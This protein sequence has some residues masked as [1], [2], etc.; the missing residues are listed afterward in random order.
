[1]F[2]ENVNQRRR[3]RPPGPSAQG[4]AARDR[5]YETAIRMISARGYEATTLREI[6]KEAGV[7]VGLV[8]KYFAKKEDILLAVIL[9]VL[10]AYAVEVPRAIELGKN[11]IEKLFFGFAAYCLVVDE[12]RRAAILAYRES[13]TLT[14][15][16]LTQIKSMERST[17][18]LFETLIRRGIDEGIFLE[19]NAML[20]A[21]DIVVLGHMWALKYWHF[22]D[23]MV[24]EDYI[25]GQ[26]RL[27]LG[28][29]LSRGDRDMYL[30]EISLKSIEKYRTFRRADG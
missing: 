6:A 20:V 29:L 11:T 12:Q 24:V 25:L 18:Q 19:T 4:V 27:I 7:S 2:I 16:G 13:K 23:S 28:S 30:S 17:T 21:Y 22:R 10:D 26:M 3:G 8:Y 15:E 5:L 14:A 1:M 9:H